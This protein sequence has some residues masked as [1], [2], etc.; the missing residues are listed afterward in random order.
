MFHPSGAHTTPYCS[1]LAVRMWHV[2]QSTSPYLTVQAPLQKYP[3]SLFRVINSIDHKINT[4]RIR[5]GDRERHTVE[6]AS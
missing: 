1:G 2:R 3:F 6:T 4:V 5:I